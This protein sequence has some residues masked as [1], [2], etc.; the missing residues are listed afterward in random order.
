MFSV[1]VALAWGIGAGVITSVP[2]GPTGALVIRN[3]AQGN[4]QC[5]LRAIA[6]LALAQFFFAVTYFFGISDLLTENPAL[7]RALAAVGVSVTFWMG[8]RSTLKT[9]RARASHQLPAG[10]C[11]AGG[12]YEGFRVSLLVAMTN[13]F[14]LFFL[15]A[16]VGLYSQTF[17]QH[18]GRSELA[19]LLSGGI[20]GTALWFVFLQISVARLMRSRGLRAVFY[21]EMTA[22]A[23]MLAASVL[24][25]VRLFSF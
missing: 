1:F 15:L 13:P 11:H 17:P 21:A 12:K 22:G 7:V 20:I 14:L 19:A 16:N 8:C 2:M 25:A 18:V 10:L 23:L 24:L 5:A 9:W 4:Q 6:G 3:V